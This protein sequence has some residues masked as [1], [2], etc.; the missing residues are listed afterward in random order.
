MKSKC[1]WFTRSIAVLL[2]VVTLVGLIPA[3]VIAD[4]IESTEDVSY[5]P[6]DA[7]GSGEIN[8]LDVTITLKYIAKWENV[9][10]NFFA[11]DVNGDS[12]VT[13]ADV[14]YMLKH[15]AGWFGVELK[16]SGSCPVYFYDGDR[17]ID[18]LVAVKGEPLGEV[19]TTQ[20]SSKANAILLGYFTDPECTQPFYAENPVLGEMNVYAKYEEMGAAEELNFTSFAQMDQ[21]PDISFEVVGVGDPE[22]AVTLEVMDGS[23]P[24]ELKFEATDGSYIVSAVDGFN[25]GSSYHK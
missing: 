10:I 2:V 19:P 6:G 8:L 9:P 25:E 20:K 15:I 13:L 17:L 4:A 3:S 16:P 7:D 5:I 12:K 1:N 24:V 23:D 21:T 18:T 11:A 22:Q 14:T